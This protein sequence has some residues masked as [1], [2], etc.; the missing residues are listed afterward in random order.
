MREVQERKEL[1]FYFGVF[2][3]F[4]SESHNFT[5]FKNIA[6]NIAKNIDKNNE[7]NNACWCWEKY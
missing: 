2:C 6:K 7:N 3:F 4:T 5:Q 1:Q